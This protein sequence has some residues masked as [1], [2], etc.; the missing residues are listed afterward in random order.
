M[1]NKKLLIL[2]T[3]LVSSLVGGTALAASPYGSVEYSYY[4]GRDRA[5]GINANAV[6]VSGGYGFNRYIHGGIQLEYQARNNSP[7]TATRLEGNI[8]GTIGSGLPHVNL[9]ST[10]SVGQV[11]ENVFNPFDFPYYSIQP[12]VEWKATPALT[13]SAA[14][15]YRNAFDSSEYAYES[16]SGIL[17]GSYKIGSNLGIGATY[18][19]S[20]KDVQYNQFGINATYVF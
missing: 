6:Q 15:R 16:N 13:L 7:D 18:T 3:V 1:V 10:V 4:Q 8:T 17:A 14:Y 9:Y 11:W 12:G 2:S 20:T 5:D 19:Y